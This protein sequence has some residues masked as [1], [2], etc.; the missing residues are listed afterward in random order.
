MIN[1]NNTYFQNNT[2]TLKPYASAFFQ[3]T[4]NQVSNNIKTSN[5]LM[6]SSVVIRQDQDDRYSL[7]DLHAA[8]GDRE[9]M[10]PNRFT[11]TRNFELLVQE[12]TPEMAS[13]PYRSISRGKN[14]GTFV[15]KEL[16]YAYA[17]WISPRFQLQVI[18]AFDTLQTQG[19]AVADYAAQDLLVNPLIY[20][21]RVLQQAKQLQ[22]ENKLLESERDGAIHLI[23]KHKR[24][25]TE[26]IR[27]FDGVNLNKVRATLCEMGYLYKASGTYRVYARH[28]SLFEE[29]FNEFNGFNSIYP[30]RK[31]IELLGRI[32]TEGKLVMKKGWIPTL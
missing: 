14:Q 2:N 19:I 5:E 4:C 30:T 29:K 10:S 21:E 17:M 9:H 6:I 26:V 24:D 11:R 22:A 3:P 20:F 18:Q 32:Y 16:V 7:N 27:K 1:I 13:S 12:L 28:K 25:L 15:C 23:G 31:G 8:A